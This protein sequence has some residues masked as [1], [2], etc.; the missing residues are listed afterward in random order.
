MIR[1]NRLKTTAVLFSALLPFTLVTPST[2]SADIEII[3]VGTAVKTLTMDNCPSYCSGNIDSTEDGG[4][5]ILSSSTELS[6][7]VGVAKGMATLDGEN[8]T[9]VLKVMTESNANT[10]AFSTAWGIQ[11]YTYTGSTTTTLD[12][13]IVIEG[14]ATGNAQITG[15]VAAIKADDLPW[16]GDMATLIYELVPYDTVLAHDTLWLTAGSG[17]LV[18]S[19]ISLTLEPGDT[20][21]LRADLSANGNRSDAADA[22]NESNSLTMYFSDNSQ[23]QAATEPEKESELGYEDRK[24]LIKT[25]LKVAYEDFQFNRQ[26]KIIIRK[27]AEL[28]GV[29]QEDTTDLGIEVRLE[30]QQ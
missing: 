12:L 21:F 10:G 4:T 8:G 5:N 13:Q 22:F 2:A 15:N 7:D 19:S 23:L 30:A 28:L 27:T 26:E 1:T 6:T 14:M 29:S 16:T 17:S 11:Q 9:P 18:G 20:F 3:G 24:Q 25:L